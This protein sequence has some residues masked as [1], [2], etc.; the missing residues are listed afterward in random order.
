MFTLEK[1]NKQ[2]KTNFLGLGSTHPTNRTV[3]F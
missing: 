3:I 2:K 1:T